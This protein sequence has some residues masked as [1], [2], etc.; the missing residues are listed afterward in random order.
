MTRFQ[1]VIEDRCLVLSTWYSDSGQARL[2]DPVME[3]EYS[4]PQRSERFDEIGTSAHQP[5]THSQLELTLDLRDGAKSDS[6]ETGHVSG[7]SATGAFRDI[8]SNGHSRRPHLRS[9]S[10]SLIRRKVGR[11][12]IDL[13]S[14]VET[15]L[16]YLEPPK[17]VHVEFSTAVRNRLTALRS[18]YEVPNTQYRLFIGSTR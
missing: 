13:L 3:L 17:V 14:D 6:Q 11:D 7:T 5:E 2:A 9:E 12:P 15:D 1:R 4:M 16:P 18:Q 10:K 8:R